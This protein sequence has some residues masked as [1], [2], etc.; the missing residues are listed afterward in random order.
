MIE[1]KFNNAQSYIVVITATVIRF[2]SYDV[3]GV[4]G[5]V[6]DGSSAIL[7]LVSPYTLAQAK[8]VAKRGYAQN[9]DVMTLCHT[10]VVI[11]EITRVSANNFTIG[12][13]SITASPFDDPTS[14]AVGQPGC[15]CYYKGRIYYGAPGKKP[16]NIYGSKVGVFND[17]TVG[18]GDGDGLAFTIAELTEPV[19]WLKDGNNSLIAGSSQAIASINGGATSTPITPTTVEVTITNTDGAEGSLPV[20]KDTLL[21]YIDALARRARYF[22]YDLLTESFISE[23]ANFVA[24]D[25]TK[26]G[27]SRMMYIKDRN[28]LIVAVRADG[29]LVSLNFNLKEKVI[30]WHEHPG[31]GDVKDICKLSDN[32]GNAQLFALVSRETGFYIE[33]MA[34][35]VEFP[36]FSEFFTGAAN[37]EADRKAYWFYT[38]ELLKQCIY[39]DNCDTFID[40]YSSE[41][42]FDGTDK[43]TSEDADFASGDVGKRIV[44]KT[45]TGRE[46]AFFEITAYI[47]SKNVTVEILGDSPTSNVYSS[48]YKSASTLAG[49]TDKAGKV[50][51]VVADG[52]YIGEFTITAG[53]VLNI[54]RQATVIRYGYLYYGLIKTF[55]LGF[56]VQGINTQTTMKNL[57]RAGMRFIASAG[58]Q[59][60]TSMYKLEDIQEFDL[61][62]YYDLPPLPMDGDRFVNFD[63]DLATEK[64]IY[65]RQDKPLPLNITS[66]FA[67]IEYGT[68]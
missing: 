22:S 63:D 38:A 5:W 30:G 1:F 34:N 67:E 18:T 48:W 16:T 31:T 17:L 8:I 4:F 25:I 11:Q 2:V 60:G 10:G 35:E 64:C 51:S 36:R 32:S 24:Y 58:G 14:G 43:I 45:V 23:D 37:E 41:I 33:R 59:V 50:V 53:G 26:G 28:D 65:I 12:A 49:L 68:K 20:R 44:Y 56:Q 7:E 66:V 57:A 21:F 39:L 54:G 62:G 55:N 46:I 9:A 47:D 19:F 3:N 27:I 15:A 52:G 29:V 61:A 40:L 42:T 13:A 6:L